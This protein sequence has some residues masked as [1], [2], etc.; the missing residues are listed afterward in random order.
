MRTTVTLDPDTEA[1]LREEMKRNGVS[2]KEALNA[3]IRRGTLSMREDRPRLKVNP[4][5]GAP[6]PAEFQ[7]KSF[8]RVADELDDDETLRELK[9]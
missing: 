2:F 1:L 3:G 4:L 8:N 7:G 5:F 6:F 9:A